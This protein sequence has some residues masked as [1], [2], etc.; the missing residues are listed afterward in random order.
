MRRDLLLRELELMHRRESAAY[1]VGAIVMM[2]FTGLGRR[3]TGGDV[4]SA[5][6]VESIAPAN[7]DALFSHGYLRSL[8][9]RVG[10]DV[11]QKKA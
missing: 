7:R 10:A 4:L 3:L 6:E 8:N 2:C 5:A 1:G 11:K 9:L